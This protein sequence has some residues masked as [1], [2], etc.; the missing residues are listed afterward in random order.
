[1]RR[2]PAFTIMELIVVIVIIG[3]LAAL[4]L[5]SYRIQML[6]MKNPEG[7]RVLLAVWEAQ[8]EYYRENGVYFAGT[9]SDINSQMAITI[10]PL[11]Y[12]TGLAAES[13]GS[14]SCTGPAVP[15]L[16]GVVSNDSSYQ[17]RVLEEGRVV[18]HPCA[19]SLC[20]QM[21]FKADW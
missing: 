17:L 14:V 11:K 3:A 16:A 20:Q 21:G 2:M 13:S 15:Y 7:T 19:A 8:K 5:P 1:M 10:P 18:C 6:K 4:A 9:I 12:F